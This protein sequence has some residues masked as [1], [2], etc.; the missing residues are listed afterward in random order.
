MPDDSLFLG[1]S[2]INIPPSSKVLK[3]EPSK[4]P[5]QSSKALLS[6]EST[7]PSIFSKKSSKSF[8]PDLQNP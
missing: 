4:G 2:V 3:R 8:R 6:I 5:M 1:R 7:R